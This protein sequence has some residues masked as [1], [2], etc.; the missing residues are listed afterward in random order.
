MSEGAETG[1]VVRP[2]FL[3]ESVAF[4]ELPESVRVAMVAIVVPTYEELV[5][6]ASTALERSAGVTLTFLLALEVVDQVEIAQT[7]QPDSGVDDAAA[8]IRD[9]TINRHL[10]LINAKQQAANFVMRLRVA[11]ATKFADPVRKSPI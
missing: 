2:Y 10:R 1:P 8:A 9:K 4:E 5:L 11:R 3:P 7:I 6:G